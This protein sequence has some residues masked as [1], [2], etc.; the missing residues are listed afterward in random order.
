[1]TKRELIRTLVKQVEIGKEEV[2]VVFRVTPDP[3]DSSPNRGS[4]Q[5]CWWGGL[6]TL[7]HE[8]P[9]SQ[10]TWNADETRILTASADGTVKLWYANVE[11]LL[12][13]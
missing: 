7:R 3:F 1:L 6:A 4:L 11:D 13:Q 12:V 9:V 2:N 5:H 8:A 10:A